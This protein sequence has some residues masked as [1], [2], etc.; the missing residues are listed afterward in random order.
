MDGHC[1][2]LRSVETFSIRRV[3]VWIAALINLVIVFL[4]A[5][6]APWWTRP[7]LSTRLSSLN[8]QAPTP[9][10][11]WPL[12]AVAMAFNVWICWPRLWQSFWHDENYPL[13]N[14]IVGTYRIKSSNSPQPEL[15]Q[16]SCQRSIPGIF[17]MRARREPMPSCFG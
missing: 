1:S 5:L 17:G 11:F 12:V 14:A 13:R 10:W 6:T 8:P 2:G 16:P 9:R 4:L 15:L 7:L 3:Y